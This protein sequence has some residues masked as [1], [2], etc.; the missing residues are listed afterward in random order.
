MPPFVYFE[1]NSEWRLTFGPLRDNDLRSAIVQFRDDP[2]C[3]KRLVSDETT[4]LGPFDQG[5]HANRVVAL[6]RHK[7]EPDE[8]AQRVGQRQDFGR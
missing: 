8:I 7:E 4:E 1:V 2:V 6:A 3:V 5:S